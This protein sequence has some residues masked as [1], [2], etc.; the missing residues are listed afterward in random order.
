MYNYCV[1]AIFSEW[2]SSLWGAVVD[3]MSYPG[4]VLIVLVFHT[5]YRG[6]SNYPWSL[7]SGGTFYVYPSNLYIM[8][9][10]CISL[11]KYL[12]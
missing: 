1:Y 10:W 3:S 8:N 2:G 9:W 11:W 6:I 5:D 12:T 4:W 7:S